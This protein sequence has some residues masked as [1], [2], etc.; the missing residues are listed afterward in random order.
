[1]GNIYR[2][3][4]VSGYSFQNFLD[5]AI[6]VRRDTEERENVRNK[7]AYFFKAFEQ[8]LGFSERD[9]GGS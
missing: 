9:G 7:G 3:A 4:K 1:M 2:Q 8:R 5:I 6:A